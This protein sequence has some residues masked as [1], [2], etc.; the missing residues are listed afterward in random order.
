[1]R[2]LTFFALTLFTTA[3]VA[4][5][6]H[7]TNATT[8]D[9]MKTEQAGWS[10]QRLPDIEQQ[11]RLEE[12]YAEIAALPL[13]Y[14]L[15]SL[16]TAALTT[17]LGV[18]EWFSFYLPS[19]RILADYERVLG[20][21]E[22]RGKV[23]DEQRRSYYERLLGARR[24]DAARAYRAAH[25]T[26]GMEPVP[27]ILDDGNA[28]GKQAAS[29]YRVGRDARSLLRVSSG[30]NHG[31]KLVVVTQPFCAFSRAAV[32]YIEG[33]PDLVEIAAK[34]SVWLMQPPTS[35]L[36]LGAIVEWNDEH[37]AVPIV[38]AETISDW[39]QI[40]FWATPNF[41]LLRDGAVADHFTGWPLDGSNR[42]RLTE[43][44]VRRGLLPA[45]RLLEE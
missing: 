32:K 16:N 20:E 30:I 38:L 27:T 25:A 22:K 8:F 44:L 34:Q 19:K 12:R 37:P 24:F 41:Y 23:S 39:P 15:G 11:Q 29:L 43:M 5:N 26:A 1:M 36:H 28:E 45:E 9:S 6:W 21:L 4:G 42:R 2:H 18:L 33:Q 35:G 40:Q 31:T 13:G 7:P 17:Q 10:K 3:S 14:D